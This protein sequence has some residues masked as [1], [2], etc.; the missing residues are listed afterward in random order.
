[1]SNQTSDAEMTECALCGN[2]VPKQVTLGGDEV[3][4]IQLCMECKPSANEVLVM[5]PDSC[6]YILFAKEE[7]EDLL[8]EQ[9][10]KIT[11]N[12]V[13]QVSYY[14]LEK[15]S[16]NTMTTDQTTEIEALRE[17]I[18]CLQDQIDDVKH[19]RICRPKRTSMAGSLKAVVGH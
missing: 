1:M 4:G 3:E 5:D 14:M 13:V 9:G 18:F 15:L 17:E 7:A 11:R 19:A 6:H 12:R 16:A 10:L 2:P 8:P